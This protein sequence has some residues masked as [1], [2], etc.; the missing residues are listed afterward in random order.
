MIRR[1]DLQ[2]SPVLQLRRLEKPH[3]E[4][5]S[6][7]LVPGLMGPHGLGR[8]L[9]TALHLSLC[10]SVEQ[11]AQR[12]PIAGTQLE[13]AAEVLRGEGGQGSQTGSLNLKVAD[14]LTL[15]SRSPVRPSGLSC[16]ASAARL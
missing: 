9:W 2:T 3:L 15:P 4:V 5:A 11:T 1:S 13:E 12:Q 8:Q 14:S 7:S 6:I 16:A 10:V